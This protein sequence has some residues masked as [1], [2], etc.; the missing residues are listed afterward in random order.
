MSE[1]FV[2]S[3]TAIVPRGDGNV[4]VHGQRQEGSVEHPNTTIS[5]VCLNYEAFAQMFKDAARRLE[6]K[7][8]G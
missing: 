5:L 1:Q 7:N 4:E 8:Y 6:E 2:F 3:V